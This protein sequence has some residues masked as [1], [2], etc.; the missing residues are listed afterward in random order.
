MNH[1][2]RSYWLGVAFWAVA[3]VCALTIFPLKANIPVAP[4][5]HGEAKIQKHGVE[6]S[7][8][9]PPP[10][11]VLWATPDGAVWVPLDFALGF[12]QIVECES[13]WDTNAVGDL[14]E[15]GLAQIY[16]HL[17]APEMARLGLNPNSEKDRVRFSVHLWEQ[18]GRLFAAWTCN[19][20]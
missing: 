11:T 9:L 13:H 5:G 4:Q 19:E 3:W 2:P 6:Y 18:R 8:I 12:N 7:I 14:G 1:Q 16:T 10:R 15:L 17:H 20:D